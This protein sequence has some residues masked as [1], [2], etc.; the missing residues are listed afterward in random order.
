M[1][2][3]KQESSSDASLSKSQTKDNEKIREKRERLDKIDVI[4]N[5]DKDIINE[6]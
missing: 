1:Q 5:I 3:E 2:K 6:D 4:V